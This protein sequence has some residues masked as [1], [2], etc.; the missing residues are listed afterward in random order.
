MPK[1]ILTIEEIQKIPQ[2]VL[3]KLIDRAK[4]YL[5]N[6]KTI[7]KMC[8]EHGVDVDFLDDIPVMFDNIEVSAKTSHGIVI[9]NYA[10]LQDGDFF[11]D[12]SYLCHEI[13]HVLDQCLG[14]GPTQGADDGFYLDNKFEQK[15]FQNQLE[16]IAN[17]SGKEHAYSYVDKV[18][19]HHDVTDRQKRQQLRKK[20]LKKVK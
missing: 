13:S 6:D 17:N 4:K 7:K 9:L 20:L 8:D 10:L 19:N 16:Y 14:Q 11:K 18:L 1:K 12:Y 3:L 2:A 15:G 5:K